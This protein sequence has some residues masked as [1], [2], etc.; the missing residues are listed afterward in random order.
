MKKYFSNLKIKLNFKVLKTF[1]KLIFRKKKISIKKKKK[2]N[3][4][5][6]KIKITYLIRKKKFQ[7]L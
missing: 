6:K 4:Y 7:I 1:F 2:N 5:M 3:N